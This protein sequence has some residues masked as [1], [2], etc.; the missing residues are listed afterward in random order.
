MRRLALLGLCLGLAGCGAASPAHLPFVSGSDPYAPTGASE[1]MARVQGHASTTEPLRPTPGNV[2]PG[3][4]KAQ[5]TLETLEQQQM[6]LPNQPAPPPLPRGSSTP[7]S[8][9]PPVPSVPRVPPVP[10][11]ETGIPSPSRSPSGPPSSATTIPTREGQAVPSGGTGSYS[12]VTLPNGT[13]G[14]MV[15]NGNG[16]S[17]IIRADGS[18][19]TVPTPK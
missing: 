12:T 15:P 11:T 16:T 7:P 1:T 13:T 9:L 14:V 18:V 5:P 6:E 3:P 19:E 8:A 17:T 4:I 10:K 2:W